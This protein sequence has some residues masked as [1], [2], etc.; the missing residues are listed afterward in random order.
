MYTIQF[1]LNNNGLL[2]LHITMKNRTG[3][4]VSYFSLYLS[5]SHP[6]SS[7][8]LEEHKIRTVMNQTTST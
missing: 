8:R 1:V 2:S 4:I 5:Y 7:T 6:P 3:L